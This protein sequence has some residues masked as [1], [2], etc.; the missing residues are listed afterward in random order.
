M[1]DVGPDYRVEQQRLR[2][3][4]AQLRANLERFRLDLIEFESR[5]LQT[6]G[7]IEATEAAIIEHDG[8]LTSLIEAHGDLMKRDNAKQKGK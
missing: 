7:N 4:V 3:Q 2:S 8:K 6:Q 1:A 5:E